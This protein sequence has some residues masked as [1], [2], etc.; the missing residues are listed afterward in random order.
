MNAPGSLDTLMLEF[1]R[2]ALNLQT[3]ERALKVF[4]GAADREMTVDEA[5]RPVSRDNRHA[6]RSLGALIHDLLD[7]F[8]EAGDSTVPGVVA[9][10]PQ[11]RFRFVLGL[12]ADRQQALQSD[13]EALVDGRN[14]LVHHLS[15]E[16]DLRS[17][18]GR[19]AAIRWIGEVNERTKAALT[20]LNHWMEGM[21][22]AHETMSAFV[23]SPAMDR[24]FTL[25]PAL[26]A[27]RAA[28]AG[29]EWVCLPSALEHLDPSEGPRLYGFR[30]WHELLAASGLFSIK[31]VKSPE[32]GVRTLWF[33]LR[34]NG[35][36]C[37]TDGP[38]A[39]DA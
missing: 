22:R 39:A 32:T 7:H 16:H 25:E 28:A 18:E 5:G 1:G 36:V 15:G 30:H 11:V 13:L 14:R 26:G 9:D 3:Y 10:V 24:V 20:R 4:L 17:E 35:E 27:F 8:L 12:D 6:G 2:C 31:R 23:S 19:R 21:Q 34:E 29:D 38:T 37:D 33:R